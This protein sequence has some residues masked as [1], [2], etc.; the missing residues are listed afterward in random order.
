MVQ[1]RNRVTLGRE[2]ARVIPYRLEHRSSKDDRC[3]FQRTGSFSRRIDR[4]VD[5]IKLYVG[6]QPCTYIL[7]F[8]GPKAVMR[9]CLS[10]VTAGLV[11]T[12][13]QAS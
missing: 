6:M 1:R 3:G 13:T 7:D 12:S 9:K 8:Q 10:P 4:G 5:S 11:F 2:K